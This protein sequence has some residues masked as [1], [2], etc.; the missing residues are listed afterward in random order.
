MTWQPI[1]T[2]P[3]KDGV[4]LLMYRRAIT[5]GYWSDEFGWCDEAEHISEE[6]W[7]NQIIAFKPTHWMPL[8]PPP[9]TGSDE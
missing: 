1:K 3:K 4:R 2:A 9:R 5:I 7:P 6:G 8:P